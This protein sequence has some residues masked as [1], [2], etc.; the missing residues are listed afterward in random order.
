[1]ETPLGESALSASP[2]SSATTIRDIVMFDDELRRSG[3]PP[4]VLAALG[5]TGAAG[6]VVLV[7]DIDGN[8]CE[9]LIGL[10]SRTSLDVG[11]LRRTSALAARRVPDGSMWHSELATRVL[12]NRVDA[13]SDIDRVAE[14]IFDGVIVGTHGSLG[15]DTME[16]D[17]VDSNAV[18]RAA[19]LG[20]AVVRARRLVDEP[21]G[22]M[23]P[24]DLHTVAAD[25]ASA[26]NLSIEAVVGVEDL[27]AQGFGGISGV[28]RGS[29]VAP[30]LVT[31]RYR[32]AHSRGRI[33]MVGKG[34]TFDSG[35]LTMKN[36]EGM[37]KQKFDMGGAAAVLAAFACIAAEG[38]DIEID[39]H[40]PMAENMVSA[41]S[42]HP[43]DVRTFR[44]GTTVEIIN[45]DAEG[46]LILGDA[47]AF[48]AESKPD[49][50]VDV[51][52]LTYACPIALGDD[53]AGVFAR[54]GDG[55]RHVLAAGD[56]VGEL[57]YRLPLHQGYQRLLKSSLADL[58]NS[59]AD[60]G[61]AGQEGGAITAA[62]FIAHFVPAGQ[63]WVHLDIAGPAW[64]SSDDGGLLRRGGTG[65][66][67]RTLVELARRWQSS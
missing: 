46:R 15:Y 26:L 7:P 11:V 49:L 60:G 47:V 32:P 57:L 8:G 53:I 63:P 67:V 56:A 39:C 25:L 33:A 9:L 12:A 16:L 5:F 4:S 34:I 31:L 18:R 35:G 40:L 29:N 30:R 28:G 27:E 42:I 52:T 62:L 51:A 21:A 37:S 14:V 58:R 44:N 2:S 43:G 64:S 59:V 3:R 61:L 24:A 36:R 48:A 66:G 65:F 22:T 50:I 54:D 19:R 23:T 10:G 45:T 1:M 38:L 41:S 20:E 17:G 6:Q 55:A 13:L